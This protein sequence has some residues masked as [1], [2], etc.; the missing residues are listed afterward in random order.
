M[1]QKIR[2]ALVG[3][4]VMGSLNAKKIIDNGRAKI[5]AVCDPNTEIA[6]HKAYELGASTAFGTVKDLLSS[7]TSFDAAVVSTPNVTHA[8]I[9]IALLEAGK[10]V[11]CEKPPASDLDGAEQIAAAAENSEGILMYG[12][13][14]RFN[15][16][17]QY[18]KAR[19]EEGQLGQIYHVQTQWQR[20]YWTTAHGTWMVDRKIAGGGPLLDIGIHR[21][22]QAL[23]LMDFPAVRSVS[24]VTYGHLGKA[25]SE[26]LSKPYDVEDF[27]AAL[28]RLE[29][30]ASLLLQASFLSYLPLDA[31][32]M[33]TLLMGT[34]CGYLESGGTLRQLSNHEPKPS[35]RVT[36][37]FDAPPVTSMGTFIDSVLNGAPSPCTATQ[38]VYVMKVI[39]AIY[40][41]AASGDEVSL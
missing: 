41:S 24:G 3:A 33:S 26:Q 27:S 39:D 32:E 8:P 7:K 9:S 12:F 30:G 40:R 17:A 35:D 10:S 38:G 13:N 21:L 18:V 31:S 16:W 19:V 28:I 36:R 22:D 14:Q 25:T 1:S 5:V 11:Y 6:K 29:S 20:R 34:E 15:P 4:G 2:F 37:Q 23:W